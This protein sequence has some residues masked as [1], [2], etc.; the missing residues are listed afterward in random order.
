VNRSANRLVDRLVEAT[1]LALIFTVAVQLAFNGGLIVSF[2]YPLLALVLGIIAA[3]RAGRGEAPGRGRAIA[4]IVTGALGLLLSI[5]L[6]A[7]G[8]SILNSGSGKSY[9]Q[10]LQQAGSDQTAQQQCATQFQKSISG[11]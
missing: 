4:G 8:A 3:R 6:V 2:V 5:A 9:Q 1:V 10:C 7:I 11:G